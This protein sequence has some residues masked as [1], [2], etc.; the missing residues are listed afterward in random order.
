[1]CGEITMNA[2]ALAAGT[3][4]SF[5]L[6]NSAIGANDNIILNHVATGTFGAYALN[7]RCAAGSATIDVRNLSAA[8]LSEPIVVRF[9]VIKSVTA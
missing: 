2:A 3:A 6:A 5:V 1:V 7:G 8:T 9:T 4:V